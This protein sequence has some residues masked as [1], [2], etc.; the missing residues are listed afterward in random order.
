MNEWTLTFHDPAEKM[1]DA[2]VTVLC[3][4]DQMGQTTVRLG[5]GTDDGHISTIRPMKGYYSADNEALLRWAYFDIE[6][7]SND[8]RDE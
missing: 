6:A 1:P 3:I 2:G 8:P 4:V 5:R 7:V